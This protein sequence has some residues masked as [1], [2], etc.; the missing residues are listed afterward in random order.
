VKPQIRIWK[1]IVLL[2][3]LCV[4]AKPARCSTD[5]VEGRPAHYDVREIQRRLGALSQKVTSF[6]VIYESLPAADQMRKFVHREITMA[7]PA[8]YEHWS[9]HGTSLYRP[10]DDPFQQ[11]LQIQDTVGLCEYVSNRAYFRLDVRPH[12][13][14]PG[15]APQEL[16]FFAVGWWPLSAFK[17]PEP[18]P[19]MAEVLKD[20]AASNKYI[21]HP[22]QFPIGDRWCHVL[23]HPGTDRLWLDVERGCAILARERLDPVT[24]GVVQRIDVTSLFQVA[25]GLWA[26]RQFR[27]RVFDRDDG[28]GKVDAQIVVRQLEVNFPPP[29]NKIAF[30]SRP[31]VIE[32]LATDHFEQRVPGGEDLLDEIVARLNHYGMC[33]AAP[34]YSFARFAG[35]AII[36]FCVCLVVVLV[37]VGKSRRPGGGNGETA[38]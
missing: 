34:K 14:L 3:A 5:A 22:E 33:N 32:I 25:A 30:K 8:F 10:G 16:F 36:P 26:P 19:G 1:G 29:T 18:L 31:G 6:H 20:V 13:Q 38:Q 15:S 9:A 2:T 17:A 35:V 4:L 11:R 12:E 21:L 27:N 24:H 23:E 28:S 7:A 37:G